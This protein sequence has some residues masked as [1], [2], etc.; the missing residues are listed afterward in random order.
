MFVVEELDAGRYE[1]YIKNNLRNGKGKFFYHEGSIYD[2]DW[3]DNMMHGLGKLH[4][5]SYATFPLE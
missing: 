3:K 1:G 5:P 4:Y 2:G